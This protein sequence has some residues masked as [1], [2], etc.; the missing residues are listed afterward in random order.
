M[1]KRA[2]RLLSPSAAAAAA[3]AAVALPRPATMPPSGRPPNNAAGYAAQPTRTP[4]TGPGPGTTGT[5]ALR[6]PPIKHR[7]HSA[8]LL[9]NHDAHAHNPADDSDHPAEDWEITGDEFFQ[10]YHFPEP[11]KPTKLDPS[12]SSVDSSSDTEGPLSPT[13]IKGRMPRHMDTMPSPRS[14]VP[15]VSVSYSYVF[16]PSERGIADAHL[17]SGNSDSAAVMQDINIAILGA[18][19]SGKSTF[20]RCALNLP[21]MG[22][23]A[24]STR[25]MTIDGGY[26]VVRFLELSTS[27]MQIRDR[28]S[29]EWPETI[30]DLPMPRIDGAVAVYDVT[31]EKSL[32][33]VPEILG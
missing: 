10:R 3:A 14:P 6:P 25:R 17:Q 20:I 4:S 5:T 15:S 21:D 11:V 30:D 19:G 9:P 23:A 29:I 27:D 13:N 32:E 2:A 18:D 1:Y 12:S 24:V 16:E 31:S 33:Y 22:L 7:A 26:Y 28:K 8:P